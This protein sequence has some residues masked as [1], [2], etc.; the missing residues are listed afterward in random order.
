MRVLV[1]AEEKEKRDFMREVIHN[2]TDRDDI[3]CVA[4]PPDNAFDVFAS[5]LPHAIIVCDYTESGSLAK[6]FRMYHEIKER[7]MVWQR[8]IRVGFEPYGHM[9]YIMYP[10]YETP[11]A[12]VEENFRATLRS[13]LDVGRRR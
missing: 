1:I 11:L 12:K 7:I 2:L 3:D 5:Y 6:G 8:I 10:T 4:S 13:L 9:D